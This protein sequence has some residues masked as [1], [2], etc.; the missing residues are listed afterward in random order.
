MINNRHREM[1]GG[2]VRRRGVM[3]AIAAGLLAMA[4]HGWAAESLNPSAGAVR[5]LPPGQVHT[6][7]VLPSTA[8]SLPHE[9]RPNDWPQPDY[10]TEA[11]KLTGF[12]PAESVKALKLA[13][14]NPALLVLPVQN[15][16]F[17]WV[18]AFN[19]LV[20][21]SLDGELASRGIEANLQVDLFDVDGPFVRRYGE[22]AVAAFA[23]SHGN[24]PVLALYL[25]RDG[26]G[27]SLVTLTLH[28]SGKMQRAHRAVVEHPTPKEAF[29]AIAAVLPS[30]LDEL[31]LAGQP[32]VPNTAVK[33]C[34]GG[35]WALATPPRGSSRTARACQALLLGVL[36]PEFE[37][38]GTSIA[39]PRTPAKLAWLAQ[40]Y[41][42]AGAFEPGAAEALRAIAWS[43]LELADVLEK[44]GQLVN[45]TDPVVR[46][47]ARLLWAPE[48]VRRGPARSTDRA[49]GDYVAAD[50]EKLPPFARAAYIERL[51]VYEQFRRVDLC[52]MEMQLPFMRPPPSCK[53]PSPGSVQRTQAA[54]QGERALLQE[55]RLAQAYKE[56]KIQGV[57]RGDPVRRKA[58]LDAMPAR[59]AA[60]PFIRYKR[61]TTDHLDSSK[62]EYASLVERARASVKD[63]VQATADV[64]RYD[65]ELNNNALSYERGLTNSALRADPQIGTMVK[66]E[67]RM[68]SV[69][70]HD[71]FM[72]RSHKPKMVAESGRMSFLRPGDLITVRPIPGVVAVAPA[73]GSGATAPASG[74]VAS[75]AAIS[76]F[77]PSAVVPSRDTKALEKTLVADPMAMLPRVHLAMAHLKQG[78]PIAQAR[79]VIDARPAQERTDQAIGE[80][81]EWSEPAHMLLFA[82]EVDAAREY[83][84]R[85]V[86]IGT[87]SGSDLLARAQLRRIAGDMA[88]A[89]KATRVQLERY[90][91]DYA[92]RDLAGLEFMLGQVEGGWTVLRPRLSVS[93]QMVLWV[94]A[95]AGHRM[96]GLRARDVHDWIARSN[97]GHAKIKGLGVGTG[98]V[99]LGR[100]VAEDRVPTADDLALL[101]GL[102]H[103]SKEMTAYLVAKARL[104]QLA[105]AEHVDDRDMAGVRDL[106]H[107]ASW[108]RRGTLKALYAWAARRAGQPADVSL[109]LLDRATSDGDLDALLA[110]AVLLGLDN[111]PVDALRFLRAARIELANL[112][113][114]EGLRD[115]V[116]SASYTVAL[117]GYLLFSKTGHGGYRDETLK[118]A[119]AYQRAD[120]FLAWPHALMALLSPTGA[121][122][123]TAACR[124]MYLD[125]DSQFLKLSGLKPVALQCSKSPW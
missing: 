90:D 96:Q 85:V 68:I 41:V 117:M 23:A 61:F 97:F 73:S 93:D 64:Q 123:T 43:E 80:S 21:A 53:P 70:D 17:G 111:R 84:E 122:R 1:T 109:A 60:H 113:S 51:S 5:P 4:S 18:A 83:Y 42:E 124:A 108:S 112:A 27:K 39:R 99:Y 56:L 57:E 77:D 55:W 66:A 28:S 125:K 98:T 120:P 92:R 13:G 103:S 47:L 62:G 110:K 74:P 7:P 29:D 32:R 59:L 48:H 104:H 20:G 88:G 36:L 40:A 65:R 38:A 10:F 76:L 44:V 15:Q 67:A 33:G 63:F 86:R 118:V 12:A 91:N 24:A 101:A 72:M 114:G 25:G 14:P 78:Q 106:I 46:P 50:A 11:L 31:G 3:R 116:R 54:T 71:G 107:K 8:D 82:G 69:L 9:L 115:D 58:V 102:E 35:D 87:G 2:D 119:H 121:A 79:K 105:F 81:H 49:V 52:G 30:M 19:A 45:S 75:A 94:G 89:Q 100:Y 6:V 34:Q 95:M 16:A 26:A 37:R 22:A